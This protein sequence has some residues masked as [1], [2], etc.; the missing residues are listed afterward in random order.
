MIKVGHLVLS[1]CLVTPVYAQDQCDQDTLDGFQLCMESCQDEAPGCVSEVNNPIDDL[2]AVVE[3]RCVYDADGEPRP[4][5]GCKVCISA[6][7]KDVASGPNVKILKPI[8]REVSKQLKELKDYCGKSL[9]DGDPLN[10]GEGDNE[11]AGGGAGK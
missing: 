8:V 4:E 11:G 6:V 9:D 5:Q 7:L 1:L 3:D 2:I 10:P